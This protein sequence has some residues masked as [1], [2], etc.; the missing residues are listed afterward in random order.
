MKQYILPVWAI[1]FGILYLPTF[2]WGDV[3][4]PVSVKLRVDWGEQTP[5][6]WNA[7]IKLTDGYVQTANSLGVDADETAV[8]AQ[9][10]ESISYQPRTNRV[11]NSIEFQVQ[12]NLNTRIQ[13]LIQDRNDLLISAKHAFSLKDILEQEQIL[14]VNQTNAQVII[15]QAPGDSFILKSKRPHLVFEPDDLMEFHAIPKYLLHTDRQVGSEI[16]WALYRSRS[17][18]LVS[19]GSRKLKQQNRDQLLK[20]GIPLS[21]KAPAEGVYDLVVAIDSSHQSVAQI[22]AIPS[23]KK[24]QAPL[25]QQSNSAQL[26]DQFELNGFQNHHDLVSRQ[27]RNRIRNSLKSFLKANPSRNETDKT[28]PPWSAYHLKIVNPDQPH[29]LV[30]TYPTHH[31]APMGF[32]ILEPDAAGQLVPVGIDAGIYQTDSEVVAPM[33]Q[34]QGTARTE[35]LFWPRIQNPV[36]LFHSLGQTKPSEIMRVEVYQ[37]PDTPGNTTFNSEND[38]EKKRLVGPYMQKPLLPEIFGAT[39]FLD[40]KSNRSLDDW[41]TFYDAGNRLAYYLN[42][43]NFNSVLLAVSADGSTIYPSQY[44]AATPR[45]DSGIYHSSG[46]DISRKDVLEMLFRI[47][48]REKLTLVPELQFSSMIARLEKVIAEHPEQA[49]GIELINI[50]GQSWRDSEGSTRGQAPFYNPINPLVQSE[51]IKI[52]SEVVTRYK[53]HP[54][55]QGVAVQLSMNGYLQLPGLKW[56]YDDLT[57]SQFEN[58]TGVKIPA[59][60]EAS[61]Y[62]KRYQFLTTS[63]LPQWTQ[64]RCRKIKEFHQ[65]L[66]KVL[67]KEQPTARMIFSS[68]ELLPAQSGTGNVIS[69][70]KAGIQLRPV[71]REMGLDFTEY[72]QFGNTSV[73]RPGLYHSQ[74][75]RSAIARVINNHPTV[76]D[77]FKTRSNGVLYYH[78]PVE[79][80]I[81]EFDQISPW[82]PAFTWLVCQPSMAGADNRVRYVH[83]IATLDPYYIFDGG[84]TI[85]FGQEYETRSIRTQIMNLPAMPFQTIQSVEQPVIARIS[86]GKEKTYYYLVNDFPYPC[87]VTV[88][89]TVPSKADIVQLSSNER[90]QT[91]HSPEGIQSYTVSLDAFDLQAFKIHDAQVQIRSVK[92]QLNQSTLSHLQAKIDQ[93]KS[94][95]LNLHQSMEKE[96]A[97][98]L[99]ADFESGT[100][101]EYILAGWEAKGHNR[102][103]W[104]LDTSEAHSGKSSLVLDQASGN[105]SLK[106][107][108][109]PLHECRYLNMSVWLKSNAKSTQVRIALEAEQEGKLKVQSAII[110]VDHQWRKYV[111]RVKDIPSNQIKNA[112]ILIEKLGADKLWIDDVDLQIHQISPEDDRQLTKLV[113]SLSFA[114]DSHRYLDCYRLIESYWGRFGNISPPH[115]A[116][117]SQNPGTLKHAE[118]RGIRKLIRR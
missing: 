45:Y 117:P 96:T 7:Q 66:A 63:A 47:F 10:K 42:H 79:I 3:K 69:A 92:C 12:G 18:E 72:A 43:H 55:F 78:P 75:Q 107:N 51:I 87:Q 61:K 25:T 89:L 85:P 41:Q 91:I 40:P 118:R 111:F 26:V 37:L 76:D 57:V 101:S 23:N 82:Q 67:Q 49:V 36:L 4:R 86:R 14:P 8:I 115:Q 103:S 94:H 105:S 5:R 30:V 71:L 17:S 54:A 50:H 19:S 6:L 32:S 16:R 112:H 33:K 110:S 48:D 27:S 44:L 70:L 95:L 29:K 31:D 11:F 113:S 22:V 80:R 35:I 97:V 60:P 84:W 15:Q 28:S 74:L 62:E 104:K 83:S 102:N 2:A 90:I 38:S 1:L 53:D 98:I 56:G 58:E 109:I 106:T 88:K 114:W 21:I 77:S 9:T 24:Q 108:E 81:P 52:F 64:W 116:V 73:L 100:S 46:Q 13:V 20:Q 59:A 68:R 34:N 65:R 39:Q 93:R 99:Q